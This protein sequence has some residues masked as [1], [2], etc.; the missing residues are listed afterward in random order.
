[1]AKPT[2]EEKLR[3]IIHQEFALL[4]H[5]EGSGGTGQPAAVNLVTWQLDAGKHTGQDALVD[6]NMRANGSMC[7]HRTTPYPLTIY[8]YK[9]ASIRLSFTYSFRFQ[10]NTVVDPSG[11]IASS[12]DMMP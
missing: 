1:M 6:M 12:S 8:V 5:D 9:T 7:Q 11:S 10:W 4:R 3:K 2:R